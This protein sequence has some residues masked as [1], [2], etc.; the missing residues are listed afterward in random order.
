MQSDDLP[1][2]HIIKNAS[3]PLIRRLRPRTI[4]GATQGAAEGDLQR[5]NQ[6]EKMRD[7]Y[8]QATEITARTRRGNKNFL[9]LYLYN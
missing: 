9:E 5:D 1:G 7:S 2:M 8:D 4:T 3:P 6:S